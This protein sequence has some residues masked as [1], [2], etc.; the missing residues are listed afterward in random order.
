MI[1][2]GPV[3]S[4]QESPQT[5]CD[6]NGTTHAPDDPLF[7]PW[8]SIPSLLCCSWYRILVARWASVLLANHTS[9][10]KAARFRSQFASWQFSNRENDPTHI[11]IQKLRQKDWRKLPSSS[12]HGRRVNQQGSIKKHEK[13]TWIGLWAARVIIE[14]PSCLLFKFISINMI[15]SWNLFHWRSTI[16]TSMPHYLHRFKNFFLRHLILNQT[17]ILCPL[18][19]YA[20][21]NNQADKSSLYR[22]QVS[23]FL[24]MES[25]T[26]MVILS[27]VIVLHVT[28]DVFKHCAGLRGSNLKN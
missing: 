19:F 17:L 8:W 13:G 20:T 4:S 24:A 14:L 21:N 23:Q 1:Q 9:L 16:K 26:L 22:I 27:K 28:L 18:P 5:W 3:G 2:T 25:G 11:S 6:G 15:Y 10:S 12:S 7:P